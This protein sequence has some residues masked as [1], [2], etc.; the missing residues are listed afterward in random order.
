LLHESRANPPSLIAATIDKL[1]DTMNDLSETR[2]LAI[3][4]GGKEPAAPEPKD[5]PAPAD[6]WTHPV[7]LE[8]AAYLRKLAAYQQ[9]AASETLKEYPGHS[10]MLS[11]RSRN[12]E[13]ELHQNY[14]DI[15]LV[16]DGRATLVTGGVIV[17]PRIV[18]PGETRGASVEGG[19][20]LELRGGAIAH[21]PAGVPHQ[22]L[23][24]SDRSFT[25]FVVKVQENG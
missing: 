24:P 3:L 5:T 8:R 9:G 23:V 11:V 22:M 12:G 7:L 20:P 4:A 19:K 15:F 16:L 6:H 18:A 2:I 17:E 25:A 13:A 1:G 10:T 14:A 21:V